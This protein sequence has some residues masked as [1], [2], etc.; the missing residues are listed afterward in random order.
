VEEAF[1]LK[2]LSIHARL[3]CCFFTNFSMTHKH[4]SDIFINRIHK[5][6]ISFLKETY[7]E[8]LHFEKD[9]ICDDDCGDY[10]SAS[11]AILFLDISSEYFFFVSKKKQLESLA[12]LIRQQLKDISFKSA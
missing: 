2:A 4:S 5:F 1:Y 6:S 7:I 9:K 11:C 3:S 12:D 8:F 10:E